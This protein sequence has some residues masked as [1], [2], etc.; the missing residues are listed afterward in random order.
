MTDDAWTYT[1]GPPDPEP[2]LIVEHP[3]GLLRRSALAE[4]RG[5]VE[6]LRD[7]AEW[8]RDATEPVSHYALR[9]DVWPGAHQNPRWWA[10]VGNPVLATVR[11]RDGSG[12]IDRQDVWRLPED[13]NGDLDDDAMVREA[14]RDIPDSRF[15]RGRG[16]SNAAPMRR[17]VAFA[18]FDVLRDVSPRGVGPER[19]VDLAESR[20]NTV[21]RTVDQRMAEPQARRTQQYGVYDHRTGDVRCPA[22]SSILDVLAD[23]AEVERPPEDAHEA[24]WSWR[25][26][27]E[28]TAATTSEESSEDANAS[29]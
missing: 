4:R 6:D 17:R 7:T 18:A 1:G 8:I 9:R 25:E 19:L 29:A 22:W 13:A 21:V 16:H 27:D 12:F 20:A 5:W 14:L 23:V 3:D 15:G 26:S 11:E 24:A 10:R 28:D 2:E